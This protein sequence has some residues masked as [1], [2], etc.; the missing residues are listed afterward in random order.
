M[1]LF[2]TLIAIGAIANPTKFCLCVDNFGIKY[3]TKTDLN[4]LITSLQ[5]NY[6]ITSDF[7][8]R[9][10]CGLIINWDYMRSFV[11]ISMLRYIPKA[12][13]KFQHHP[14]TPKYLPHPYHQPNYGAKIKYAKALDAS[15]LATPKE[16]KH[17]QSMAST[18]LYY[19]RA[20][21]PTR[22]KPNHGI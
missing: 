15:R 21:D 3:F 9:N 1:N 4:C 12:L 7:S 22:E 6:K 5:A 19:S 20:V 11:D 16:T 18:I 10:Y 8:G 2:R 14:V 13:E 17:M